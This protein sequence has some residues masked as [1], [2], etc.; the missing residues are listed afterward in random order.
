V[1]K[2]NYLDLNSWSFVWYCE[3]LSCSG[4]IFSTQHI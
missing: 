1:I 3:C 4:F 2:G